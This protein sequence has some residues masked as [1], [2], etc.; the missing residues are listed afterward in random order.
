M[1]NIDT[2]IEE[3]KRMLADLEKQKQDE[4]EAYKNTIEWNME[5]L[6]KYVESIETKVKE[7]KIKKEKESKT[8]F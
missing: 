7:W 4:E 5:Q 3:Q 1:S 8:C 6:D 2:K